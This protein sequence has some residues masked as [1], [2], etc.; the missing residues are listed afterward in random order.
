MKEQPPLM[1]ANHGVACQPILGGEAAHDRRH[2]ILESQG[3]APGISTGC[4]HLDNVIF[5]AEAGPLLAVHQERHPARAGP[6]RL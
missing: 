5:A 4:G 6:V 1:A 2:S 3:A